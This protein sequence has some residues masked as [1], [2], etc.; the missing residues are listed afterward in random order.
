[1]ARVKH[2]MHESAIER[3]SRMARER[4]AEL[5]AHEPLVTAEAEQHGSYVD[6][7]TEVG[8]ARTRVKVN[9][10]GST[11]DRWLNAPADD[12]MGDSERAA[13]R[14][15]QTLWQRIDGKGQVMIR[16]DADSDG[17][18]E[19]DALTELSGFKGRFPPRHWSC[20]ENIC[21]HGFSAES[22][23]SRVVVAF[24]A[25]MIAIWCGL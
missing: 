14:Y 5:Q 8:G 18:A 4:D 9:R 2:R 13:I 15:C 12:V 1:M 11:I 10:G 20:F 16:V 23:Q 21:R 3:L 22:R 24:V 17:R 19:H 7:W 25:G 6:G